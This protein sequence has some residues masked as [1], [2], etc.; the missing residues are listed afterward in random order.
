MVRD[1]WEDDCSCWDDEVGI[2]I[3]AA[4]DG[5]PGFAVWRWDTVG[6]LPFVGT[7]EQVKRLIDHI[8]LARVR[9]PEDRC[10]GCSLRRDAHGPF[11][12]F[13][14]DLARQLRAAGQPV[15]EPQPFLEPFSMMREIAGHRVRRLG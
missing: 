15:P 4:P 9:R 14:A 12:E 3:G 2:S 1:G 13:P 6:Y 10:G 11:C 7:A 5:R 8:T